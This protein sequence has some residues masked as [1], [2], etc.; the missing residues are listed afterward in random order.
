MTTFFAIDGGSASLAPWSQRWRKIQIGVDHNMAPLYSANK[1]IDLQFDA[2]SIT[3]HKQWLDIDDG[4]S[5]TLDVL[6]ENQL[7]YVTLSPVYIKVNQYP[8][9]QATVS[10]EFSLTILGAT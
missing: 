9:I 2:A 7:G 4:G 6:A 8:D 3:Y 1:E 10:M 5:H